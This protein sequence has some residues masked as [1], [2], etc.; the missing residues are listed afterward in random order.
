MSVDFRD[1]EWRVV[2]VDATSLS[3]AAEAI[4]QMNEAAETEWFPSYEYKT[5]AGRLADVAVTVRIRVTMPQW[6]GYAL[7]PK[8]EK[9]EW[10][11]FCAALHEHERGHID[12]VVQHLSGVD[13]RLVGTSEVTAKREWE[14]AL[15]ALNSASQ[16]FDRETNHGRNQGTIININVDVL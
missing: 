11:R 3:A 2:D 15:A 9:D 7:A 6:T 8:E 5:T 1:T 13:E 12:L 10:D 4:S 14:R 16:S